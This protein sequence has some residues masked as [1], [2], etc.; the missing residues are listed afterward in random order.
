MIAGALNET[1]DLYKPTVVR[2]E[3]GNQKTEYVKRLTTRA[4]VSVNRGTRKE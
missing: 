1:I 2:D 4:E 3:Y